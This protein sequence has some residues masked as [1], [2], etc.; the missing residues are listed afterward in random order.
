[1]YIYRK[2]NHPKL[3]LWAKPWDEQSFGLED[4]KLSLNGFIHSNILPKNE[5]D[6]KEMQNFGELSIDELKLDVGE[7]MDIAE[8]S[9][10]IPTDQP[11]I[12]PK[13]EPSL[14]VENQVLTS[15]QGFNLISKYVCIYLVYFI[16]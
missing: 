4:N 1:M 9:L 13:L 5:I 16:I 14:E 7:A 15:E 10:T 8:S 2:K 11:Q 6:T 3:Y 12:I